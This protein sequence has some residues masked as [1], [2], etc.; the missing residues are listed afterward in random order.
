VPARCELSKALSKFLLLSCHLPGAPPFT[1]HHTA[2]YSGQTPRLNTGQLCAAARSTQLPVHCP[3][4][5]SP[6]LGRPAARPAP[7]QHRPSPERGY[8]PAVL[9]TSAQGPRLR[10]RG[11]W[12]GLKRPHPPLCLHEMNA[13]REVICGCRSAETLKEFHVNRYLKSELKLLKK[14]TCIYISNNLY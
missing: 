11:Q 13:H 14:L 1:T 6:A 4:L 8:E 12:I 2:V 10:P 3:W 7:T 9:R 5:H